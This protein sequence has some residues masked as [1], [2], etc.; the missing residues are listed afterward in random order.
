MYRCTNWGMGNNVKMCKY[1]NVRMPF[2]TPF[3]EPRRG[4]IIIENGP[5]FNCGIEDGANQISMC[6]CVDVP[7][8]RCA[9]VPIEERATD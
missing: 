7:M 5:R 3:N 2:E 9:D 8:C 4:E 1:A 6:Q